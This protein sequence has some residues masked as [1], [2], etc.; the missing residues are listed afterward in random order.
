MTPV[1]AQDPYAEFRAELAP[2]P[3]ADDAAKAAAA[4][5]AACAYYFAL[6]DLTSLA[7]D[8]DALLPLSDD[9][10]WTVLLSNRARVRSILAEAV[11]D[12]RSM[13]AENRVYMIAMIRADV[14]R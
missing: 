2:A 14:T 12:A 4:S 9:E 7:D 10:A 8:T 3:D 5:I 6:K 13:T 1:E 11:A